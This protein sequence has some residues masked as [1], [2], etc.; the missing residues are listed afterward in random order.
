MGARGDWVSSGICGGGTQGGR[1]GLQGNGG[2]RGAEWGP[3][4]SQ[5]NK[6]RVHGVGGSW[7]QAA[8]AGGGSE[9]TGRF[10]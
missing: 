10:W 2:I 8:S 6:G 1:W 5:G 4:G 3:W 7:G 9:V